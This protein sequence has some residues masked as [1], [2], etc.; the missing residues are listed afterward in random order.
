[1]RTPSSY[2]NLIVLQFSLAPPINIFQP[3]VVQFPK[4]KKEKRKTCA[5]LTFPTSNNNNYYEYEVTHIQRDMEPLRLIFTINYADKPLMG[6]AQGVYVVSFR[7]F[8]C[9]V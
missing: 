5:W 1:M 4:Q 8:V 3:H 6:V 2:Y 9:H 7:F